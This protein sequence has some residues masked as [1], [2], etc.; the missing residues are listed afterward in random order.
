[1]T[2]VRRL[3]DSGRFGLRFL[4]FAWLAGP[5]A[6]LRVSALAASSPD[7]LGGAGA[8]ELALA[9]SAAFGVAML[10]RTRA[11]GFRE[12]AESS[13]ALGFWAGIF[14]LVA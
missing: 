11:S 6:V 10:W 13:A 5:L 9:S 14:A 2:A 3:G 12:L 7:G 4:C 8:V 1:M